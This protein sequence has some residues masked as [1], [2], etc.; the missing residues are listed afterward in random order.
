MS[1]VD[2]VSGRVA[3]ARS[4]HATDQA[5]VYSSAG[6]L[7]MQVLVTGHLG[8]IGTVMVPIL[9]EAG[10]AVTGCDSDLYELCTYE[11]GGK[12]AAVRNIG[13]DVRDITQTDLVGFDAIIHLAALS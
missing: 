7:S 4:W 13:K 5:N 10:H 8:Y 1:E 6:V 2:L 3:N 9:I 12:I 11:V